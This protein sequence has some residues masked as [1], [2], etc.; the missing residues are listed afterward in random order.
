MFTIEIAG[1]PVA[2]T[3]AAEDEAKELVASEP[4]RADLRRLATA[5]GPLWDGAAP[6]TIRPANEDE[7]AAFEASEDDEDDE[8]EFDDEDED[9]EDE[10][11]EDEDD[12]V[13]VIVF[14]VPI[15]DDD[16]E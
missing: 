16:E 5:E 13:A 2:V 15:L 9:T 8:D 12:E 3:D 4:F 6:L 10:D 14:L 11:A 7:T 1:K